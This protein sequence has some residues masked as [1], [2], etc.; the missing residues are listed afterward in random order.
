MLNTFPHLLVLGFFAPT[1]LRIA[2]ACVFF[3]AAYAVQKHRHTIAHLKLPI[4]GALSWVGSFTA[5]AY[6]IIGLLL[7]TGSYTQVAAIIG[8][9]AAAKGWVLHT[10]YEE[11]FPYSKSTYVLVFIICLSLVI[12]GAGAMAFDLP[13]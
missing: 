5:F 11:L 1:M 13:L 9:L 8:A 3:C 2:V 7:F 12:S 4:I 10:N 6:A